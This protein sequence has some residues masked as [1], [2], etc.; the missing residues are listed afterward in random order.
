[1]RRCS[2]SL[3]GA[4]SE[5]G[6]AETATKERDLRQYLEKYFALSAREEAIRRQRLYSIEI[7]L[8]RRCNL[9][10]PYCYSCSS[11]DSRHQLS[12]EL[13]Q[14]ALADGFNYGLR[15]VS[16]FGGEPL[17]HPDL[18][19]VLEFAKELGYDES[20]LYTNGTLV[21][22]EVAKRLREVV[23]VVAVHLDTLSP[24]VFQ[25]IHIA[26]SPSRAADLHAATVRAF[27]NLLAAGYAGDDLRLTLT[28]CRPTYQ[29]IEELLFWAFRQ[30]GLQTSI[31]IPLTPFG[32]GATLDAGW[33]LTSAEI[34]NA[35]R[36]RAMAE[37][38]PY[39]LHLG[40]SEYCKQ[41]QMSMCYV[42]ACGEVTPYAGASRACGSILDTPL[43]DLIQ[44]GFG[45]LTFRGY[46]DIWHNLPRSGVCSQCDNA[47][48]CFGTRVTMS[49]TSTCFAYA[50]VGKIQKCPGRPAGM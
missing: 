19:K 13:L 7:E 49:P 46:S 15:S 48:Y 36:M 14:K 47:R 44:R 27:D 37:E 31:F 6:V 11:R 28:L 42:T 40:P 2:T 8:T 20:V 30:M 43:K 33:H 21:T 35:Y 39:L 24:S 29:T 9:E 10:C 18:F 1:M 5:C 23:D 16:W 41:Y 26:K 32:R 3:P 25:T 38:R 34:K 22:S 45:R 4:S 50:N 17:L 12:L